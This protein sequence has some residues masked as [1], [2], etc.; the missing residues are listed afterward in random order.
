MKA[1]EL[2][3]L[4]AEAGA[5]FVRRDGDHHVYRLGDGPFLAIP[6]GGRQ[7]E[8]STSLV[9]KIQRAI[10]RASKVVS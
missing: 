8:A 5:V 1:R 2:I 9:R 7:S 4:L 3:R 6:M 10:R